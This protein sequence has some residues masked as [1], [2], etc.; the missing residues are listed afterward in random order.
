MFPKECS[1][2]ARD[3]WMCE[4]DVRHPGYGFALHK[5][6]PT[7]AHLENLR[8]LGPC[9]EHRRSFA[10]VRACLRMDDNVVPALEL[11]AG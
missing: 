10:P 9:A 6:Y 8:R 2:V 4:L 1:T 5:G 7:P 11:T 3:R